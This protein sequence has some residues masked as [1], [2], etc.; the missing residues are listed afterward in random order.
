MTT[1]MRLCVVLSVLSGLGM[2]SG[3]PLAR[4][5]DDRAAAA[6]RRAQAAEERATAAERR[7][8]DAERQ[9]RA[10]RARPSAAAER[11]AE[12]ETTRRLNEVITQQIL[13]DAAGRR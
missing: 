13:R 5:G 8:R 10:S 4:A 6:E 2:L 1:A 7:A 3:L 9:L 12:I 11:A